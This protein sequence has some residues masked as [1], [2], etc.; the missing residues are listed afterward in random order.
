MYVERVYEAYM[1]DGTRLLRLMN[2][3]D[4]NGEQVR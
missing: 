4:A 3:S 1:V 2:I